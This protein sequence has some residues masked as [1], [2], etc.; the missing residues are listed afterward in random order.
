MGKYNV[1][2]LFIKPQCLLIICIEITLKTSDLS[3]YSIFVSNPD[4]P[5][6]ETNEIPGSVGRKLIRGKEVVSGNQ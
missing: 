4:F 6:V 3:S 2:T 5:L 1:T